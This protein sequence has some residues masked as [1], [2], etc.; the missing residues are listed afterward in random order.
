[1]IHSLF[2]NKGL[3]WLLNK[4]LSQHVCIFTLHRPVGPH[5]LN[6]VDLSMLEGFLRLLRRH[7]C[8]FISVDTL[9]ARRA[10]LDPAKN[11]VCF[12]VDD[13]YQ[14]QVESLIPILLNYDARPT[15]F[16]ITDLIDKQ[17]LPWDAQIATT[18]RATNHTELDA[19][20][21]GVPGE[22]ILSLRDKRHARRYLSLHAKRLERNARGEF[23][24]EL[25]ETLCADTPIDTRHF[26]PTNWQRLQELEAQGLTV[27]SH[28]CSHSPLATLSKEDIRQEL[29]ESLKVLHQ[30]LKQPSDVFC[31]PVGMQEDFDERGSAIVAEHGFIGALTS[32]PGYFVLETVNKHPFTV[33]RLSLPATT[34]TAV[35]YASW[36]E[37][38]RAGQ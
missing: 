35:R 36:L 29:S 34:N 8:E 31:Y 20:A 18:I 4:A 14:D 27:G 22:R 16:V 9:F 10:Q 17:Q 32:E 24:Q 28:T 2:L 37:K 23:V 13:G 11:Y 7:G 3:N 26:E 1:M 33:P 38:L 21:L 15:L 5:G 30:Y 6:G 25:K 19:G 12:T